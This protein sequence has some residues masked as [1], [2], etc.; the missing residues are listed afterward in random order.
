MMH[1]GYQADDVID[2]AYF[3]G[4]ELDDYELPSVEDVSYNFDTAVCSEEV[5]DADEKDDFL[6][7]DIMKGYEIYNMA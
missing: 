1:F 4:A 3:F 6:M 5:T 2:V 7:E